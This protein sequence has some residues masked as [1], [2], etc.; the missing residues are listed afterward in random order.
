MS[1]QDDLAEGI[2]LV[3]LAEW[4]AIEHDET[5]LEANKYPEAAQSLSDWLYVI[6]YR[7]VDAGYLSPE[8]HQK[9]IAKAVKQDRRHVNRRLKTKCFKHRMQRGGVT[10]IGILESDW[11]AIWQELE[12]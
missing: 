3:L 9:A 6:G 8:E 5:R 4:I 12:R 1:E 11:K 2:A 7:L 10:Y